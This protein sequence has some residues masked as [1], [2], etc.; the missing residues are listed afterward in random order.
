MQMYE[1]IVLGYIVII[2]Y[3]FNLFLKCK[4]AENKRDRYL[5]EYNK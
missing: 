4:I 5:F 3:L 1:L 2:Y